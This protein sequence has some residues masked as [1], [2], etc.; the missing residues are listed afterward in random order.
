MDTPTKKKIDD[1]AQMETASGDAT[2][3]PSG[4]IYIDWAEDDPEHPQ[5]WPTR[6][7]WICACTVMTFSF[8]SASMSAGYGQAYKGVNKDL[9]P[10]PYVAYESGITVYLLGIAFAPLL[11]A[12]VSESFGRWPVMMVSAFWCVSARACI[13]TVANRLPPVFSRSATWCCS[14]ARRWLRTWRPS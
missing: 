6:R 2:P 8:A 3:E 9:G 10:Y 7:K 11:L 14:S 12:P 1:G 13:A 5:N 4:A